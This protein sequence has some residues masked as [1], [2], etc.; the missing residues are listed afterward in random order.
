MPLEISGTTPR[1]SVGDA[2]I[3]PFSVEKPNGDPFLLA[4]GEVEWKLQDTRTR[5]DVLSLESD[6]VDIIKRDDE[7]GTFEIYLTS[8]ATT[9]LESS[10]YRE[11]LRFTD[12]S[13]NRVT[14]TGRVILAED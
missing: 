13:G 2:V 8:M 3:L 4:N 10:D 11:V 5:E 7:A 9:D 12:G 6:G 14:W 1:F